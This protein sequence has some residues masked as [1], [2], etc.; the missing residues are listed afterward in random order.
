MR[1]FCQNQNKNNEKKLET[2]QIAKYGNANG[3]K[4]KSLLKIL[5]IAKLFF[6][7]KVKIVFIQ[8]HHYYDYYDDDD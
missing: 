3:T 5:A 7:T 4:K 2:V 6:S 1:L 8:H